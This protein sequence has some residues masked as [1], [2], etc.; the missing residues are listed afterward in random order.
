[1]D[2]TLLYFEEC[3][4]WRTADERLRDAVARSGR[5]VVVRREAIRTPEEA[6][7]LGLRGSPTVLVDGHDPFSDPDA[8]TGLGCRIYR[9]ATGPEG[10]PRR[11][12]SWRCSTVAEPTS[13]V[14]PGLRVGV[15]AVALCCGAPG[16]VGAL[17]AG[18]GIATGDAALT[19]LGAVLAELGLVLLPDAA[20]PRDG[21]PARN[22]APIRKFR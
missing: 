19:A 8:P 6:G 21:T 22:A 10:L 12:T 17:I 1:M 18:G 13:R 7:R 15:G 16:L 20:G 2:V 9:S 4:N 5:D 11:R 14:G 3:P